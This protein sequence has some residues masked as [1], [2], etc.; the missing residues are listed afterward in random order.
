MVL[1]VAVGVGVLY[2]V[3]STHRLPALLRDRRRVA[4]SRR[5]PDSSYLPLM[6]QGSSRLRTLVR[7]AEQENRLLAASQAGRSYIR[8]L[9]DGPN[10]LA[11]G[12]G[13]GAA[14][15]AWVVPRAEA[16]AR[17]HGRLSAD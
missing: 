9:D 11:L 2:L 7:G 13:V 16:W 15:A 17:R 4:K 6:R 3:L 5:V 8:S 1:L 14:L 10:R 12:L